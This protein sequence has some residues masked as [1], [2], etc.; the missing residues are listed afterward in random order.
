MARMMTAPHGDDDGEAKIT[1]RWR[2]RCDGPQRQ[3]CE[4][5]DGV[6]RRFDDE[7]GARMT[8]AFLRR[9]GCEDDNSVARCFDDD[10]GAAK[11]TV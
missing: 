10:D 3:G 9:R 1:V 5:D 2:P 4:D 6:A 7:G 11:V 8:T